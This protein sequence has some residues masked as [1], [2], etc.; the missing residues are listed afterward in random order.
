MTAS[1]FILSPIKFVYQIASSHPFQFL[2]DGSPFYLEEGEVENPSNDL[3]SCGNKK[4]FLYLSI[5][6]FSLLRASETFHM[7]S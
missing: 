6:A 1:R 2:D 4:L 7:K 3:Q 5:Q